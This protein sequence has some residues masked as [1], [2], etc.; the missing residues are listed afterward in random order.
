MRLVLCLFCVGVSIAGASMNPAA[1][2]PPAAIAANGAFAA[3]SVHDLQASVRWYCET[4]DMHVVLSIPK[5]DG[6]AV[7]VAEGRGL[8]VELIENERSLP[9]S[10]AAPS[11]QER[12]LLNGPFKFGVI[13]DDFDGTL[14]LLRSRHADIAYGPYAATSDQ[15]ANVIIRDNEGNLLQ[16]FGARGQARRK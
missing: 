16:F 12:V 8:I 3:L 6:V 4:L 13:V 14:A 1:G 10:Q 5:K 2:S 11:L 9:L 7:A 15:R